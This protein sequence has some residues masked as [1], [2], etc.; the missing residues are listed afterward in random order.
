V[1][2]VD[3]WG[4]EETDKHL[5]NPST[6]LGLIRRKKKRAKSHGGR[7]RR[8]KPKRLRRGDSHTKTHR[9]EKKGVGTKIASTYSKSKLRSTRGQENE[10]KRVGRRTRPRDA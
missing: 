10:K 3:P 8:S 5:A 7:D 9:S 2:D 4:K 6:K 1:D